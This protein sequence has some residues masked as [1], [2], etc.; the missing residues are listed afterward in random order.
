M[1]FQS[2][3]NREGRAYKTYEVKAA[4]GTVFVFTGMTGRN[5]MPGGGDPAALTGRCVRVTGAGRTADGR[6]QMD[7]VS[8]IEDLGPPK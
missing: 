3:T 6:V 2:A 8:K 7:T 5:G 4:D 1:V